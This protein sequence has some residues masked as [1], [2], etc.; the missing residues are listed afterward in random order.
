MFITSDELERR[1]QAENNLILRLEI[2]ESAPPASP[3]LPPIDRKKFAPNGTL[4]ERPIYTTEEKVLIGTTSQ[5]LG[6]RAAAEI[7]D[8]P[9]RYTE[10][11]GSEKYQ[12]KDSEAVRTGIYLA[13]ETIR[14]SAR[15]KLLMALG[16]I[17]NET[18]ALIPDKDKARTAAQ[19]AHQLSGVI[20]RTIE[21]SAMQVDNS[22]TA[23]LHLY[24]PEIRAI[25]KF[26]IKRVNTPSQ[27]VDQNAESLSE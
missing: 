8:V 13:L 12:T 2:P 23:H 24:S 11:V 21:K 20:D 5:L 6:A 7:F 4:T 18:L 22:K 26:N 17:D 9:Q 14:E 15:E 25:D 27:Q 1:S 16:L 3:K 19:I 10:I